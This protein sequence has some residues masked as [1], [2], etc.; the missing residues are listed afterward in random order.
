MTTDEARSQLDDRVQEIIKWH[1]SEETGTP[2]WLDWMK[3][4]GWD[5]R[6]EVKCVDDIVK[7]DHFEDNWL[8]DEKNERFVPNAYKNRPFNVFETGGTTGL[9]KQRVGWDDYKHDYEQFSDQ[10]SDEY[11]P[12]GGNWIMVGPTGPRR[13]RLAVEHLANHRGGSCYHVD[14]D[15][16]W[17]KKLIG[18]KELDQVERYQAHVMA[19][20]VEIIKHRDIECIF[21]TPKLLASIGERI[22]ISGHGIKG[23]FCGGTSMTPEYVRFLQ[24]EVLEDKA[25]FVPTYG[26]TLMGLAVSIPEELK[27]NDYSVTYYAPQPRAIL[28]IVDPEDTKKTM[29][30]DEYG[31]V[32]LTTLTKEFFM[33]R[34]LERDEAIRRKPHAKYAWDG[35]G[36]VRPFGALTKTVIEGVY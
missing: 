6:E 11:F 2:F 28:R 17:V 36:D 14:L 7:F 26:N 8:R 9:P 29:A 18:R 31:R 13:L 21:T 24:E 12:K 25:L 15:P 27:E 33:P 10:L 1:F 20:A 32:E 30:Y 34:F 5:P 3:D 16:R 4:A 19:Q 23:C 22:S 35:V